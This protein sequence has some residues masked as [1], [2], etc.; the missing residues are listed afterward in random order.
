MYFFPLYEKRSQLYLT[1]IRKR[2]E[3]E[4]EFCV[5]SL[6]CLS[7]Q[8]GEKLFYLVGSLS[9]HERNSIEFESNSVVLL[10]F[11]FF[12]P[13]REKKKFVARSHQLR[14]KQRLLET[15]P[16]NV[17]FFQGQGGFDSILC[18]FPLSFFARENHGNNPFKHPHRRLFPKSNTISHIKIT[19][20]NYVEKV[21]GEGSAVATASSIPGDNAILSASLFTRKSKSGGDSKKRK[22]T[23]NDTREDEA[24]RP[25]LPR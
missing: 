20:E 2:L 18:F 6:F 7:F 12:L 22:E 11:C 1:T 3:F 25:S 16:L 19:N 4:V 17:N 13:E 8:V 24:P 21:G 15:T 14:L 23:E 5:F 9:K 10:F